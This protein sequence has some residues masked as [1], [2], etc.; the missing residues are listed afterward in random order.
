MTF[1]EIFLL[2]W[3][4]I[5]IASV[6]WLTYRDYQSGIDI[7]LGMVIMCFIAALAGPSLLCIVL[8]QL[9]FKPQL[10]TIVLIKGKRH[11]G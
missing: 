5:G 6:I 11:Y 2:A 3:V 9:E 4:A 8:C 1:L 7:T 10:R